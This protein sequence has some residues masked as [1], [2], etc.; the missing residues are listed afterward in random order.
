M[1][2][3]TGKDCPD[4]LPAR[5]LYKQG[6]RDARH[7]AAELSI[8]ADQLMAEMGNALAS[9]DPDDLPRMIKGR[10]AL[11]INHYNTYMER[12]NEQ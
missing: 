3:A 12:N 4:E 11:A 7:A 10:V 8:E 6:H 5:M 9:I 1:N 2:Q